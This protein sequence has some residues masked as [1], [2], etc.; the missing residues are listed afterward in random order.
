MP[1]VTL[2]TS[3]HGIIFQKILIFNKTV[4]RN[5]NLVPIIRVCISLCHCSMH[6]HKKTR[7]YTDYVMLSLAFRVTEYCGVMVCSPALYPGC[8]ST[9]FWSGEWLSGRKLCMVSPITSRKKPAH[10]FKLGQNCFISWAGYRSRYGDTLR[11][12]RSGDRILAGARFSASVQTVPGAHPASYAMGTVCAVMTGYR[13]NLTF[14]P[15]HVLSN[16]L[17]TDRFN[18]HCYII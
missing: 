13:V 12:G 18:S 10:H 4:M 14:A 6:M 17:F 8:A 2:F 3:R 5:S 11:A 9:K 15:F 7:F 1:T 16:S